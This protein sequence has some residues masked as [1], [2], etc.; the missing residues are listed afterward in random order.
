MYGVVLVSYVSVRASL[1]AFPLASFLAFIKP[2]SLINGFSFPSLCSSATS[3]ADKVKRK[4]AL[5]KKHYKAIAEI[6]GT[7]TEREELVE[8]LKDYFKTDNPRFDYA[9]FDDFV[10]IIKAKAHR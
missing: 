2:E 5:S 6:I 1:P 9:R 10:Q 3:G 7:T 8:A 4:M